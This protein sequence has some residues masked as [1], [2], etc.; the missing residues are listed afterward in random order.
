MEP[1]SQGDEQQGGAPVWMMTYG[2]S[3]TLL[4]TFF[5][6]LLT[7]STPDPES[8]QHLSVGLTTGGRRLGMFDA[9]MGQDSIGPDERRLMSSRLDSEG[10]EKPP[11]ETAELIQEMKH[12]YTEID[13]ARL[14]DL[15]GALVVRIPVVELFGTGTQVT[16]SGGK[17]L[18]KFVKMTRAKPYSVIVRVEAAADLP[19]QQ[20]RA[21]SLAM[22]ARVVRYISERAGKACPDIGLSDNAELSGP[23][24]GRGQCEITMLEV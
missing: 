14:Q 21:R 17:V 5:V 11:T 18:E 9:A 16:E 12:H 10:A 8:F 22:A 7:F 6:L 19:E 13:I 24:V 1:E 23:A 3:V 2:D 15:K 20:R 4:L